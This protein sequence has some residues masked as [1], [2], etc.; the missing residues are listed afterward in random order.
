MILVIKYPGTHDITL[1]KKWDSPMGTVGQLHEFCPKSKSL[2]AYIERIE[3]FFTANDISSQKKVPVFLSA[4]GGTTYGLLRN[5]LAW[6]IPKD[7]SFNEIVK[8]LK[9]HF[10]PKPVDIAECFHF[11]HC[12]KA[13]AETTA[14]YVAEL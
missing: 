2:T 3:I 6:T 9:A 11:H 4:V 1:A 10:E 7:K 14:V 8:V 13:P 12:D 5:L